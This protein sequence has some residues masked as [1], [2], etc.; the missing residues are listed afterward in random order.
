MPYA[1]ISL[2]KGKPAEYRRAISDSVYRAMVEAFNVPKDDLFQIFHQLERDELLFDRHY[3]GGPRSDD[4]VHIDITTGKP[5]SQ[6]VKLAFYRRAVELLEQS[7]GIAPKDVM[8][9][10]SNSQPEDWSL[11]NGVAGILEASR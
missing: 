7:P 3:M 5:R 1:R 9:V 11:A 6:E 10:L 4:F 8:I 2:L